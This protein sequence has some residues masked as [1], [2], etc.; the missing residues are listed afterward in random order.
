[1]MGSGRDEPMDLSFKGRF[2]DAWA[3]EELRG[4]CRFPIDGK[5][6]KEN[7]DKAEAGRHAFSQSFTEE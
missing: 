6:L 1:M 3:M 2:I 4:K 5:V 7:E